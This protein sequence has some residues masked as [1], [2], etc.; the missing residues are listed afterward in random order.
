MTSVVAGIAAAVYGYNII[1]SVSLI[2]C[3]VD[4]SISCYLR[5]KLVPQYYDTITPRNNISII[6][7]DFQVELK[8]LI[9]KYFDS[10]GKSGSTFESDV[11]VENVKKENLILDNTSNLQALS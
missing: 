11:Q 4:L 1:A 3:L 5:E 8:N 10:D 7:N 9:G 6:D 2:I